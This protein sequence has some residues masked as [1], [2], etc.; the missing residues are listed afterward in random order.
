MRRVVFLLAAVAVFA[1][2]TSIR[3]PRANEGPI[4]ADYLCHMSDDCVSRD[5]VK[6]NVCNPNDHRCALFDP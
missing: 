1:L 4:C 2:G 6:C 5:D 3:Q